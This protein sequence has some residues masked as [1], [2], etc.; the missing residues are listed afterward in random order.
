MMNFQKYAL[1]LL[2]VVTPLVLAGC[3]A[4]KHGEYNYA[5]YDA[6][7]YDANTYTVKNTPDF[8]DTTSYHEQRTEG[9]Q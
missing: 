5:V 2:F 9:H 7:T 4:P 1:T 6:P 3:E 8:Y